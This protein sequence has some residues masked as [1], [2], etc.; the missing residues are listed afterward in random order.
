MN[1]S[2]DPRVQAI[3]KDPLVGKGSCSSVD[4]CWS[5]KELLSFLDGDDVT[6]EECIVWAR[7]HEEGHLEQGLNARWGEDDDP[8][9]SDYH[10]FKEARSHE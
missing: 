4:E 1:A 6:L 5:D 3:R 7:D 10:D 8:Q 9:L 2:D